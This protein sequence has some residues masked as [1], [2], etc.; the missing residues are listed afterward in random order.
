MRYEQ[1]KQRPN[2]VRLP[3]WDYRE[4]GAYFVTVCTHRRI[5]L[6][7]RVHDGQMHLNKI[8]EIVRDEWFRTATVRPYVTVS[9]D[10]FVVMPNH[11][12]GIVWLAERDVTHIENFAI[13]TRAWG[14][15]RHSIGAIVGQFKSVTSKRINAARKT[16]GASVW[17]RNYYEH[18]IRDERA[19][20]AIREY[21]V[22]NP[23]RWDLDNENPDATGTD[24]LWQ[25]LFRSPNKGKQSTT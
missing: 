2:S 23:L 24:R 18:V 14:P 22:T 1:N 20:D 21:I 6:F 5:P 16:P 25:S 17:Q 10:E 7:G 8:G 12:H 4:A 15:R 9:A 19:L 3:R 13:G 11:I